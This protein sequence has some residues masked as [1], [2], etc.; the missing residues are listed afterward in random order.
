MKQGEARRGNRSQSSGNVLLRD[1]TTRDRGETPS[2]DSSL[3]LSQWRFTRRLR[4]GEAFIPRPDGSAEPCPPE[5]DLP[6]VTVQLEEI[7]Y[8]GFLLAH[9]KGLRALRLPRRHASKDSGK[10]SHKMT[11][12]LF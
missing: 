8:L 9:K 5:D 11:R 6:S 10:G 4:R 12:G 2:P 7:S 1:L 3:S